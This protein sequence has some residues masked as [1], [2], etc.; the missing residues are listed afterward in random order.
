LN[1]S[2]PKFYKNRVVGKGKGVERGKQKKKKW[3]QWYMAE[4]RRRQGANHFGRRI[5]NRPGEI[6]GR[7]IKSATQYK[8]GTRGKNV[9]EWGETKNALGKEGGQ[10]CKGTYLF[11]KH[12][13]LLFSGMEAV[14]CTDIKEWGGQEP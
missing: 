5:L 10:R 6:R 14:E 8:G 9:R 3:K 7:D 12:R 2:T 11:S 13:P 4:G 1:A